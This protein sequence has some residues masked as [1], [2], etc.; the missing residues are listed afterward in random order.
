MGIK[1]VID[2]LEEEIISDQ[3][4]H[5]DSGYYHK[6]LEIKNDLLAFIESEYYEFDH[7]LEEPLIAWLIEYF[8]IK[9]DEIKLAR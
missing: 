7:L 2:K 1:A 3:I 8:E 4:K 9:D 5:F 6:K